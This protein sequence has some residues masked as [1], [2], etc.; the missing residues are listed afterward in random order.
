M[1][2]LEALLTGLVIASFDCIDVATFDI[3]GA[4]LHAEMTRYKRVLLKLQGHIVEI[5]CDVNP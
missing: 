5:M 4:Y 3:P 2:L 1:L